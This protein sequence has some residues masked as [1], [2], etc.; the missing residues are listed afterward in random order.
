MSNSRVLEVFNRFRDV[1]ADA[2]VKILDE[3][4]LDQ[5]LEKVDDLLKTTDGVRERHG[6][7]VLLAKLRSRVEVT[8]GCVLQL[9]LL[10]RS[11]LSGRHWKKLED[12]LDLEDQEDQVLGPTSKLSVFLDVALPVLITSV[13]RISEA[14]AAEED[15]SRALNGISAR[16]NESKFTF[17][18]WSSRG[19]DQRVVLVV[20]V[21]VDTSL[22]AADKGK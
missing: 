18:R 16:W 13:E 9:R 10:R 12:L 22:E 7:H 3:A 15:V 2:E 14:V 11:E 19:A 5:I 21:A 8:R 4:D 20:L 1:V 17:E 6:D